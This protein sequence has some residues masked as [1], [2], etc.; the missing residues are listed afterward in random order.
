MPDTPESSNLEA[1]YDAE[2]VPLLEQIR[3]IC[4]AH[5]LPMLALFLLGSAGE[6]YVTATMR[7]AWP[8][9]VREITL[10]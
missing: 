1:V 4:A 7:H 9:D 10:V 6:Q 5:Q 8:E 3:T 2:I